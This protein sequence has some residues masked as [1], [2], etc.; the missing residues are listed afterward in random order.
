PVDRD[1]HFQVRAWGSLAQEVMDAGAAGVVAMRYSVYVV[2]A[3]QFVAD[4]YS[5]LARGLTLGEAVNLGRKQLQA[6]PLREVGVEPLPLADWPVPV[7]YEAAPLALFPK[8]KKGKEL[9]ITVQD[10]AGTASG[11]T[12][13]SLPA[14][15]DA[16][17]FGRDETILALD[18]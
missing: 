15:P 5:A 17:F 8:Q 1:P 11:G 18:R 9:K 4:L 2:T 6:S 3:A 7:V 13:E 14:E 16:G 12:G 10:G